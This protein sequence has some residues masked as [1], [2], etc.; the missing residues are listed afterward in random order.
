MFWRIRTRSAPGVEI[1]TATQGPFLVPSW[2]TLEVLNEAGGVEIS[3]PQPIFRWRCVDLSPPSGPLT[4]E[5]QVVSER[6]TEIIQSHPGLEETEFRIP[7]PLPFNV[8]LRW[9]VIAR[10]RTGAADTVSSLGPFV[11]TS[12]ASPPATLLYQNFPNPFPNQE[13][14]IETTRVWF[15]LAEAARVEL[16][17]YDLRGRLVRKLIPREGCPPVELPAG[18]YGRETGA[19]GDTCQSFAWDGRDERDREV[20]EGVYL[21]RLRADG[22]VQVR[23]MVFWR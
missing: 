16:A 22:F 11:V 23:R 2:V 13:L 7:A 9:R 15:D 4:F 12:G 6:E 8:P 1:L 19:S 3:E 10:G 5:L 21:L 18:T 20:A 14:G 17:V